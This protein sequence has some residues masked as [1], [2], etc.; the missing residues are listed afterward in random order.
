MITAPVSLTEPVAR[1]LRLHCEVGGTP[2]PK[3]TWY[4]NGEKIIPNGRL[5]VRYP[6]IVLLFFF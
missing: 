3:V 6:L 2:K 1:R 4:K 5:Q